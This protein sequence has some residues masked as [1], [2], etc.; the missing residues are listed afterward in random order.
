MN[1]FPQV[2]PQLAS[3]P[4]ELAL[5]AGDL[6]DLIDADGRLLWANGAQLAALGYADDALNG[7]PLERSV[8]THQQ[9]MAG[10]ELTFTMSAE[11]NRTWATDTNA[12]PFSMTPF[13]R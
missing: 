4:A 7:R 9:I 8:V 11:P 5:P 13:G 2:L 3:A 10:G 12:R 6:L 1:L